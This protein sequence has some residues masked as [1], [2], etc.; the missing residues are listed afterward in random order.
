MKYPEPKKN[1]ISTLGGLSLLLFYFIISGTLSAWYLLLAV[2]LLLVAV[3][4]ERR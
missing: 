2:P 1:S 4:D 3:G